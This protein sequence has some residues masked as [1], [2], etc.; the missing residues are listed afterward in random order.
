MPAYK[1]MQIGGECIGAHTAPVTQYLRKLKFW[2]SE[3]LLSSLQRVRSPMTYPS[4]SS[5]TRYTRVYPAYIARHTL[6]CSII[7]M[8][9]SRS[10]SLNVNHL[11]LERDPPGVRAE[12]VSAQAQVTLKQHAQI[13]SVVKAKVI[14]VIIHHSPQVC[15]LCASR[16]THPVFPHA[17]MGVTGHI[18]RA[19]RLHPAHDAPARCA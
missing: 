15:T 12:T 7:S 19:T 10:H 16:C 13:T 1:V 3:I 14:P 11:P 9:I 2:F 18:G 8:S 17:H 6:N 5:I 4:A